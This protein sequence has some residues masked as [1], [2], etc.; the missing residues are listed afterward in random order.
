[1]R[2]ESALLGARMQSCRVTRLN[3][4]IGEFEAG[5]D[6]RI[7]LESK[8]RRLDIDGAPSGLEAELRIHGDE[9]RALDIEMVLRAMFEFDGDPSFDEAET[10]LAREA[11][12]R[13]MDVARIYVEGITRMTAFPTLSI[14]PLHPTVDPREW[15]RES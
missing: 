13:I 1:M 7:D 6:I 2:D 11:P 8:Y 5:S 15:H 14:P 12:S 3:M 9:G 10:F 4:R